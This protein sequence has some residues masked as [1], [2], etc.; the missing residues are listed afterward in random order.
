MCVCECVSRKGAVI[1]S[2][3]NS[4]GV[5]SVHRGVK[6]PRPGVDYKPGLHYN[7]GEKQ[8][9]PHITAQQTRQNAQEHPMR[10]RFFFLNRDLLFEMIYN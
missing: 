10:I 3:P 7:R 1:E 2:H 8:Q 6:W 4:A 5:H 9:G